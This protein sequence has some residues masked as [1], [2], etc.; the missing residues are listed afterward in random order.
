MK[1]LIHQTKPYSSLAE[2]DEVS[3]TAQWDGLVA[4][5]KTSWQENSR[6]RIFE[7]APLDDGEVAEQEF[8]EWEADNEGEL[9]ELEGS[10]SEEDENEDAEH[11]V[12]IEAEDD[13]GDEM[14]L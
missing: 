13:G 10:D 5:S 2:V 14:D 8:M 6:T 11:N 9:Q 4:R 12:G 7:A 3:V 1:T